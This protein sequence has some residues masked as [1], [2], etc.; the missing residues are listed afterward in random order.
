VRK[1]LLLVCAL[2]AAGCEKAPATAPV[3]APA[4]FAGAT[5]RH[6]LAAPWTLR[7]D[8]QDRGLRRGYARGRFGGRHVHVPYSPNARSVTGTRGQ[9]SYDGSVAWYR[10][11][12]PVGGG[13]YAIRFESVNHLAR[14]WIDGREI[15]RHTGTYLPFEARPHLSPGP[16]TLVVRADWRGPQ[17]MKAEG[18]HRTWFNFGGINREVT[19]RR[20][21]ASELDSPGVITRLDHGAAVVTVSVRVHN[22]SGPRVLTVSGSLGAHPLRFPPVRLAPGRGAWVRTHVR[23]ADPKLWAPGHPT[24]YPLRLAVAGESGYAARVGLREISWRRARLW[25]NGRRLP[26]RG[27]SLQEDSPGRG[28]A[29]RPADMDAVVSRLRAIHANLTRSQH[30]LNPALLERLDAAGILVWQGIG[31]IDQPGRWSGTTPARRRTALRRVRLNVL[32]ARANP[33]VL[34]WNLIN[35]VDANGEPGGQ[36]GYLIRAAHDV[37]ALDRGR[38]VALDVWG[39]HLPARAGRIYRAVDAIGVTDYEGWY[40][41]LFAPG[42]VVEASIKAWLARVHAT[43]AGKPV[44]V[45]EFGAESNGHNPAAA[46]GGFAFQ[47]RRLAEHVAAYRSDPRLSGMLVWNLQDFAIRPSFFGGSVHS[48]SAAIRLRRGINAKG[49]FTYGGRPKPAAAVIARLFKAG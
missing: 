1:S 39:T 36:R 11:R 15:A 8:P 13:D 14:V 19:I 28:D 30:P 40:A 10:T 37:H 17:R 27:A 49:L 45:T 43:F 35:E 18:W 7:L 41:D 23:V 34:A 6:A 38:P 47:S 22:R 42:A 2:L 29:L 4:G 32:Q 24:L 33:S 48:Q 26:L 16:H 20:L 12:V 21:G 44:V 31:P 3:S 5:G 46:P 9:R 25:L